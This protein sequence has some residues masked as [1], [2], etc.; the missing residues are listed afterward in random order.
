MQVPVAQWNQAGG[1][2]AGSGFR[3]VN[4]VVPASPASRFIHL[5]SDP[6]AASPVIGPNGEIYV[7]TQSGTLYV[8][9]IDRE[10]PRRAPFERETRIADLKF[11]VHTPAVAADG[12]AYCLCTTTPN[13]RDHRH[14]PA[15]SN[16]I[17]AVNRDGAVRWTTPIPPQEID[18]NW[19]T[20]F[21][22]GALRVLSHGSTARLLFVVDYELFGRY[23][24]LGG[25]GPIYVRHL[26]ILDETG[27]FR[28]FHRY[29]E[30]RLYVDARGGGGIGT[31]VTLDD[32]PALPPGPKLPEGVHPYN[33][34]PVVFGSMPSN[35]PWTIVVC[36]RSGL[37]A[38]RWS[39]LDDSFVEQPGLFGTAAGSTS[40]AAFANGLLA[41]AG[42]NAMALYDTDAFT[43]Y[44]G[45]SILGRETMAAGG[46]R[47]IYCLSRGGVLNLV[48]GDGKVR[49]R[50]QLGADTVAFPVLSANHVHVVTMTELRT[51]TL[52]LED[53]AAVDLQ[54]LS[55]FPG[56]SSPAI[57][58]DGSVYLAIGSYL[59]CYL[60][61]GTALDPHDL[62][63]R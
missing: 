36:G 19:S 13:P 41:V 49:K 24:G 30:E 40:P 4:T 62:V 55:S 18:G 31:T 16:L 26:G 3:A 29:Q 60:A 10:L 8:C 61:P 42:S 34:T 39:Y 45:T 5:P 57:G 1:N 23:P 17:V 21:V 48:D 32:L 15:P 50:R 54:G 37:Y 52:D 14:P 56:R 9:R 53:V 38:F 46:L 63:V 7:G 6:V 20:G 35:D 11:A 51:L 2:P 22:G 59:H 27:A 43:L 12:T 28:L 47:Q 33:N 25:Q 58:S 44:A